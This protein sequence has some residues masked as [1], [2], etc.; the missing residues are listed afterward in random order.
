VIAQVLA[1]LACGG[2]IGL[3]LALIGSGGSILA[4]P[5]LVYG[6]GRDVATAAGTSLAIVG[7][8]AATGTLAHLRAGRVLP[9]TGLLFGALGALGAMLGARLNALTPGPVVLLLFAVVMLAS[10]V[11][12]LRSSRRAGPEPADFREPRDAA[13]LA[14]IGAAGSA[15][16]LLSGFFGVGGGFLIIP[17]LVLAIRVPIHRAVGTSLVAIVLQ[18]LG[19][20]VGYVQLGKVD[21]ALAGL[22]LAGGALGTVAG[23]QLAGRWSGA[24]LQQ[25]FASFVIVVALFLVYR[26]GAA[27]IGGL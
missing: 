3:P 27:L 4:V 12:M 23:M 20:L 6:F 2:A 24:R 16:G 17:A 21:F 10:A 15:V 5:I 1:A 13:S 11:G 22:F 7:A 18:S 25:A 19:G 8:I 14:R 26:N 9:L